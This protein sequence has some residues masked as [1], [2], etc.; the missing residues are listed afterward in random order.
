MKQRD[1]QGRCRA[2]RDR[3]EIPPRRSLLQRDGR[4]CGG[5]GGQARP[6]FSEAR[7]NL[8]ETVVAGILTPC[9]LTVLLCALQHDTA[10]NV[11]F[12]GR[13]SKGSGNWD[14]RYL[15]NH[16]Q[17]HSYHSFPKC[18]GKHHGRISNILSAMQPVWKPFPM[19]TPNY[20]DVRHLH[21]VT[22][23]ETTPT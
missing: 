15:D 22:E 16:T 20:R 7:L 9:K 18:E 21:N 11:Y 6:S 14:N 1:R 2:D 8:E 3:R 5:N 13:S 19:T 4:V 12:R 17:H 23:G 10:Y